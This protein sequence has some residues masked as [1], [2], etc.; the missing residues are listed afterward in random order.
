MTFRI[1]ALNHEDFAPLFA[2][3]DAQLAARNARRV[4]VD[5]DPGYPCRISL[6]DARVGETV[7]LLNH[8]SMDAPTPFRATHAIYVRNGVRTAQPDPDEVPPALRTRPQS[9]RA[10]D[11][12]WMMVD[13]DLADGPDQVAATI[14]RMF[15]RSDVAEI[16]LHNARLGCFAARATRA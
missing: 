3:D 15:E 1:H 9:V 14:D 6:E 5:A 10:F 12:N 8:A 13:A 16:H 7:I 2:M 4:T 11:A